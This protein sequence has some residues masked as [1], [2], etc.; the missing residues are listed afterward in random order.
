MQVTPAD[1]LTSHRP[2]SADGRFVAYSA[3]D[4][5]S[6][7]TDAHLWDALDGSTI[8]LTT[9]AADGAPAGS[10]TRA[11]FVSSD[12]S[13][14]VFSS[15]SPVVA[16]QPNTGRHVWRYSVPT[17]VL[18]SLEVPSVFGDGPIDAVS[19][20]G[21]GGLLVVSYGDKVLTW[22][23]TGGFSEL[24]DP[25][26]LAAGTASSFSAV[27]AP[28]SDSG[29]YVTVMTY[30]PLLLDGQPAECKRPE[31]HDLLDG[32]VSV[33]TCV[34]RGFAPPPGQRRWRPPILATN[35]AGEVVYGDAGM[36]ILRWS[37]TSGFAGLTSTNAYSW[38]ASASGNEVG[39]SVQTSGFGGGVGYGYLLVREPHGRAT[40]GTPQFHKTRAVGIGT[41]AEKVLLLSNDP[42]SVGPA[43]EDGRALYLWTRTG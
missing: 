36:G 4:E 17:G 18:S 39:F 21:D 10:V 28:V 35:D 41:D 32:G 3:R 24:T 12:G 1:A 37:P 16:G 7:V 30:A 14:V 26:R 38:T 23:A 40:L 8:A 25:G 31:L 6:G 42:A 9:G 33:G 13:T 11:P 22:T 43:A 19:T 34:D 29:R 27:G 2:M 5:D 15:T 20:S